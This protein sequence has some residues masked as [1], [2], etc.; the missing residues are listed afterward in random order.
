MT[1]KSMLASVCV[2]LLFTSGCNRQRDKPVFPVQGQVFV[3]K[4][5]AAK[6]LVILTPVENAEP[7]HWPKGFPRGIAQDDGTFQITSYRNDD[8]APAGDYIATVRWLQPLEG[9]RELTEDKLSG[10]YSDPK[11]SKLR[12]HISADPQ[13]NRLPAFH[14]D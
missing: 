3:R 10:R 14:L 9:E 8:G 2:A 12:V 11:T 5:P 13:G 1:E 7:E 4:L 6:A